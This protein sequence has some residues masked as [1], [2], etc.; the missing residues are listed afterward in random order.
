MRFEYLVVNPKTGEKAETQIKTGNVSLNKEFF[1]KYSVRIFLFQ[2]NELYEGNDTNN[3]ICL[4]RSELEKFLEESLEWLP[5]VF[6]IKWTI[7]K[8]T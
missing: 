4:K 8:N 5:E 1:L 7:V 2:S 3:V 6:K